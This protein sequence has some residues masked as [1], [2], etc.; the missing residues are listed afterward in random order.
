MRSNLLPY[1]YTYPVEWR[2]TRD[3]LRRRH[4]FVHLR[5]EAYSHIQNTFKQHGII[6]SLSGVVKNKKIRRSLIDRFNNL[7]L[8]MS[9]ESD[10]DVIDSLDPIIKKIELK[11]I[12]GAKHHDRKTHDM[13]L[14]VPGIGDM[15]SLIIL[16]EIYNINRF[17]TVQKFSS[18]CGLVKCER[19]SAGKNTGG[20][21][22]KIRNPYL[23]W[24]FDEIILKAQVAS[25]NIKKYYEKLK[26]RHGKGKA[27][28]RITHKFGVAVFFMLQNGESFDEKRFLSTT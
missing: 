19:T 12:R 11:I 13:L 15:L 24:A 26:A 25:P 28:N 8:Q 10:L 4:R 20:A 6:D 17:L 7:D 5:A 9:I 2:S 23:K 22:G 18:Y 14:A 27:K 21:K 16:Y 3:L 1:A